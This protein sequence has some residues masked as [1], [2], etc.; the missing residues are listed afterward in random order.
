MSK[1]DVPGPKFGLNEIINVYTEQVIVDREA[2][3]KYNP[4]R[5]SAAGKCSRELGYEFTEFRGHAKY[6]KEQKSPDTHRLLNLG[7]KIEWHANEEMRAA[8]AVMPKPPQIKYKQH[9]LS[10]FKFD[11]GSFMEGK[12]DLCVEIDGELI[13]CDWKSKGDKYSAYYKSAWDEFP[14]R[15]VATGFAQTFG[16][17]AVFITDIEKFLEA[18]DDPFFANNLYQLNFY[19]CSE[20]LAERNCRL[21]SVLQ[22]N[23][24]DSRIREVRFVPSRAV[25]ERT[26]EKFR[27][28]QAAVDSERTPESIERDYVLGSMKCGFCAYRKEC[29]PEDDALKLYFKTL[30]PKAWPKD[31]DRLP[32]SAQ[33]Q[34]VA[35]FARYHDA[36]KAAD[37]R[38]VLEQ[39][40]CKLLNE[41]K[42]FK[43]RL[44]KDY[45]YIVK[46]LKSGGFGGA[47]RYVLRRDKL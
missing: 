22:Y 17:D 30:P 41:I 4:L 20:F 18:T 47:A 46:R 6:Q 13:V 21:A 24:N 35:L 39:K 26:V 42:I 45:I 28:V 8:F 15:L 9:T 31:L 44:D 5:P 25:F 7:D 11:D 40:I 29:W 32:Q 12:I 34:L 43:V 38:E 33:E 1:V 27:K 3:Y 23:K 10:F 14:N 16:T 37:E 19:A 2:A 36:S